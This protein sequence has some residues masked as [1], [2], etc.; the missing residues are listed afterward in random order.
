L[1]LRWSRAGDLTSLPARSAPASNKNDNY[2]AAKRHLAK[3]NGRKVRGELGDFRGKMA[4]D[5]VIDYLELCKYKVGEHT[6]KIY[7]YISFRRPVRPMRASKAAIFHF[8]R[9]RVV[10]R[11][12]TEKG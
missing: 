8:G 2:E 4:V 6:R 12:T 9:K 1:R 5:L 3:M 10:W 7:K 11:R